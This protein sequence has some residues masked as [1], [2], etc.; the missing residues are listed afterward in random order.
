MLG[1]VQL[2]SVLKLPL[3][4]R[5]LLKMVEAQDCP[6]WFASL[7]RQEECSLILVKRRDEFLW[8]PALNLNRIRESHRLIGHAD[9]LRLESV[10]DV[11]EIQAE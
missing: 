7:P 5:Q 8:E 3:Q 1:R 10:R 9:E 2:P 11:L 6:V 4:R